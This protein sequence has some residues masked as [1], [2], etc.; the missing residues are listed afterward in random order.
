MVWKTGDVIPAWSTPRYIPGPMIRVIY[1]PWV[2]KSFLRY[3]VQSG[4]GINPGVVRRTAYGSFTIENSSSLLTSNQGEST[5]WEVHK[6]SSSPSE[7]NQS[8][9]TNASTYSEDYM[10]CIVP[11]ED[12]YKKKLK[13]MWQCGFYRLFYRNKILPLCNGGLSYEIIGS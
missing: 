2:W 8:E 5:I 1:F 11:N 6:I 9:N 10:E 13:A 3:N 4:S 12:S 7:L